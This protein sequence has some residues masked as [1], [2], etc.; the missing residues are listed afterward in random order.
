MHFTSFRVQEP[1]ESRGGRPG[2]SVLM[3]LTVSVDVKQVNMVLNVHINHEAYSGRGEGG[4]GGMEVGEEG[5]YI[6]I[7]TLLPPE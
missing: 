4:R 5:D 1:C 2:L 3:S 7:A 6:P